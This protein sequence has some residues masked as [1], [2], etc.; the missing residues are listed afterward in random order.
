MTRQENDQKPPGPSAGNKKKW[1][2]MRV[3]A[4]HQTGSSAGREKGNQKRHDE[5]YKKEDEREEKK[6]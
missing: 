3:Y 2:K 6:R 5:R 4:I 1:Y